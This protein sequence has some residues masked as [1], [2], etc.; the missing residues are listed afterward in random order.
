M[1]KYITL[2]I[3]VAITSSFAFAVDGERPERHKRPTLAEQ[4]ER[5][6]GILE[7]EDI[8]DRKKA[9][10]E[11]RLAVMEIQSDFRAAVKAKMAELSEEATKEERHEAMKTVRESFADA[12]DGMKV[13]RR[14]VFEGRRLLRK[15]AGEDE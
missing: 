3:A 1:K 4:I 12:L 8:S 13:S 10:L 6:G 2:L 15:K 7:N 5:I 14:E 11:N 9:Y